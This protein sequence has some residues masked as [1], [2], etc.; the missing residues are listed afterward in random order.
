MIVVLSQHSAG[1]TSGQA[2]PAPSA[3]VGLNVFNVSF[4]LC[5]SASIHRD[6]IVSLNSLGD[7]VSILVQ[8]KQTWR[9]TM[10]SPLPLHLAEA[11]E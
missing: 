9:Q 5:K 6:L 11:A 8:L 1:V 4:C 7:E 3:G 2:A 10:D